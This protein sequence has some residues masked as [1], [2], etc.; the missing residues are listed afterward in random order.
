M[1][2]WSGSYSASR[3]LFI[4]LV[5]LVY[6]IAFISL[7][8]QIEGLVGADG[9]LPIADFLDRVRD[10]TGVERYWRLPTLL[11]LGDSDLALHVLCGTGSLL[12][13]AL[14]SGFG[15]RPVLASLWACYLS[16]A[17]GG[18][19]FLSFQWDILLLET[20][21]CALFVAPAGW[22]PKRPGRL[23]PPSRAG[24]WL[25]WLLLFK[26]MFLSGAVK[27]L[28]M[29]DT[30]WKLT[31][32]DYHYWTQPIPSSMSWYAHQLPG[33]FQKLSTLVT[34][35]IEIALP[36]LIFAGRIGRRIVAVGTVFLMLMISWTG[37]YGFFNLLTI[38]L[39]VPLIDDAVF[40][41]WIRGKARIEPAR[42][43]RVAS[44][45][46]IVAV[47]LLLAISALT[48][49]Q[50]LVRTVPRGTEGTAG[51][52]ARA[53]DRWVVSWGE[54]TVLRHTAPFRT[55]NGYGLFR[56]MTI[57]RPEI[58]VEGSR[59]GVTWTAYAFK[60]KPG[61]PARP[62]RFVAPHM[63]RLDWQ[64]WFAALNPRGAQHWLTGLMR[65]ILRGSPD[66]LALLDDD[67][68]EGN[69][70]RYVRLLYY[71]YRFATPEERRDQSVWW[72]REF[73]GSLTPG[74]TL[75]Q[76]ER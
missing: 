39:C 54:K 16:L 17:L 53:A 59:D 27:P 56:S 29:D 15:P 72:T 12:S 38:V 34:Y 43:H 63:P 60:W 7:W 21:F 51:A 4:R 33:W 3:W 76:L 71:K 61:D 5:G 10:Q 32:L 28:S 57:E 36:F 35:A 37:N 24:L 44:A 52:M 45:A 67:P 13:L 9:I 48:T 31:A 6:L 30:W 69:P 19:T 46:A 14:M 40:A 50:E 1:S 20:G 66:V 74:I 55:I 49:V 8:V 2:T 26:L 47:V 11:W 25:L 64:M 65:G 73:S 18:Q 58:V 23:P 68:F 75:E 22:L 41:R 70:P 42:R 62:P